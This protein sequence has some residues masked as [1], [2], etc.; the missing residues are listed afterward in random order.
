M[1]GSG[2]AGVCGHRCVWLTGRPLTVFREQLG[3]S[4]PPWSGSILLRWL[5]EDCS[6]QVVFGDRCWTL[7]T[8][9]AGAERKRKEGW[10]EGGSL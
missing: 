10:L 4:L 8:G 5:G 2:G 7:V 6:T 1:Q 3:Q 9:Q